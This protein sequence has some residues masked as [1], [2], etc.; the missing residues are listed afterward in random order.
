MTLPAIP[1]TTARRTFT[2]PPITRTP[3]TARTQKYPFANMEVGQTL[4][5]ATATDGARKEVR[6]YLAYIVARYR[7]RF[8]T[9]TLSDGRL[10]IKRLPDRAPKRAY[11]RK[12]SN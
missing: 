10:A 4:I 11:R 9:R 12:A 5:F 6:G 3:R 2:M 1:Y 8:S 7:L